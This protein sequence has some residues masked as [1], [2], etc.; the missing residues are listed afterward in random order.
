[1]RGKLASSNLPRV[2]VFRSNKYFYAQIIDDAKNETLVS[3]GPKDGKT[4]KELAQKFVQKALKAKI[5]K[6]KFDRG[7]YKY[8]GKVK[9][10]AESV[11][12]GGLKL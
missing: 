6:V 9:Q 12:E 7:S 10:F 3:V 1:M 8:H 4:I 2:S 11:R 5:K